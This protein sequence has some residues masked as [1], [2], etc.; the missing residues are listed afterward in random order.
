MRGLSAR[1][2]D[3]ML[4]LARTIADLQGDERVG[5]AHVHE[6]S[7][8]RCLDRR[9]DGRPPPRVPQ[10]QLARGAA[11]HRTAGEQPAGLPREGT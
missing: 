6:A 4:K 11:V 5:K 3:R 8:L 2:H 7:Q 10:L 1:A 9:V